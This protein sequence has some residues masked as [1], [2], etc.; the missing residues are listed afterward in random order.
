MIKFIDYFFLKTYLFLIRIK[1]DKGDSKWSAFLHT[2]IY[3]SINLISLVCLCGLLYENP[4]SQLM[5]RSPFI[6]WMTTFII[7][8]LLLGPRYYHYKDFSS[9]ETSYSIMT[10]SMRTFINVLL[11]MFLILSPLLTFVLFRLY[12]IGHIKWW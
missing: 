5:K 2:G 12:V 11:Y 4:L 1:K 9:I 7:S 6:F 3:I 8:P 10:V